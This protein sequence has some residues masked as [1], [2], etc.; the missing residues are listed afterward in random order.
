MENSGRLEKNYEYNM[1]S[2]FNKIKKAYSI[3]IERWNILSENSYNVIKNNFDKEY[4]DKYNY[5]SFNLFL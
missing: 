1:N 3:D 2:L 4:A 5:L